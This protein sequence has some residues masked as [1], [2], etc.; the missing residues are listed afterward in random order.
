[1]SEA[2][3]FSAPSGDAATGCEQAHTESGGRP[4]WYSG[5]GPTRAVAS[6]AELRIGCEEQPHQVDNHRRMSPSSRSA[7]TSGESRYRGSWSRQ[8]RGHVS[9]S[10]PIRCR[11]RL[12]TCSRNEVGDLHSCEV[13]GLWRGSAAIG[14]SSRCAANEPTELTEHC[15]K[16]LHSGE[17][18]KKAGK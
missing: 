14:A 13:C 3:F 15:L 2:S 12:L 10:G 17:Q 7:H 6:P 8:T 18:T 1:V 16:K 4:H 5:T 9:R 11:V